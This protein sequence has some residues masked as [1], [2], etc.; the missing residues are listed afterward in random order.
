MDNFRKQQYKELREKL[1]E[2]EGL[3]LLA[4]ERDDLTG[5]LA[6]QILR[7]WIDLN[8]QFMISEENA[9][10]LADHVTLD[11]VEYTNDSAAEEEPQPV[12]EPMGELTPD[13]E[14]LASI[15]E[16]ESEDMPEEEAENVLDEECE[17]APEEETKEVSEEDEEAENEDDEEADIDE[18]EDLDEEEDDEELEES[19]ELEGESGEEDEEEDEE[20][21]HLPLYSFEDEEKTEI[22]DDSSKAAPINQPVKTGRQSSPKSAEA[23]MQEKGMPSPLKGG[24]KRKPTF[25]LND[26]FLFRRE[27][28]KGDSKEFEK[29]IERLSQ[30]ADYKDAEAFL[31]EN[32]GLKPKEETSQRFLTIVKAS[33]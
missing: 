19:D 26:R 22:V 33:F 9:V 11:K 10:V 29:V 17:N 24:M 30:M 8:N 6:D 20:E 4:E 12:E 27:F 25:S 15:P 13:V 2:L 21:I 14:T 5:I 18:E 31:I 3:L 32:Y 7:K 23:T 16:E 28:F 1:Y